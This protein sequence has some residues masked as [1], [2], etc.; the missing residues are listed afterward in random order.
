MKRRTFAIL[1]RGSIITF[2]ICHLVNVTRGFIGRVLRLPLKRKGKKDR[3]ALL[4]VATRRFCRLI[5]SIRLVIRVATL[6][7]VRLPIRFQLRINVNRTYHGITR[8]GKAIMTTSCVV[9]SGNNYKIIRMSICTILLIALR[10]AQYLF[11]VISQA[12]RSD[13]LPRS[14]STKGC[15]SIEARIPNGVMPVPRSICFSA[16][17]MVNLCFRNFLLWLRTGVRSGLLFL[18]P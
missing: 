3:T 2:T 6:R 10:F 17:S 16:L 7:R 11:R 1:V 18:H 4:F 5:T 13:N 15:V 9:K 14:I 8:S 12:I